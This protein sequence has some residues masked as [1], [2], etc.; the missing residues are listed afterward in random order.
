MEKVLV[1]GATGY[2]GLHCINQLLNEGYAVNGSVRSPERKEEVI[3]ALHNHNTSSE[4]L[5]LYAL[6]LTDDAGWSEAMEDCD[7]LLHVASPISL[8][9]T[10]E[11]Y[12]VQPAIDGVN[13]ALFFAKK[14]NI[15][16]VVLTSSVA[17]IFDSLEK[18]DIYDE[19][20]WSDPNNPHI[21]AYSKSKTLAEK[22]AWEFVEKEGHPF[23]LAVI[24][25][26]LVVG[27]SLSG[28]I[29]ESN[30]AV[31]MVASGRMPVAVPLMFGYVDVRDVAAAHIL[32]M[33]TPASNGER[34]ALVEKDLWYKDVAKILR[35]NGFEKA[36]TVGI[37]VWLAKILANFNK[38]LK[39]TLPYLGRKR[40]IKNLKAKEILGWNPRPAE[41][42]ILDI[43]NQMKDLGILK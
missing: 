19:S 4:Y 38:E 35:E 25:P 32:A 22:A 5:N 37:P 41:E 39:L 7:Y 30:K 9:R 24:N 27:A 10:D 13:R 18:K 20:D 2:I 21:S 43:A 16:K 34:F 29:G 28:D 31:E 15:K 23:E 12:F 36:P 1:T 42:S 3:N 26:A 14:H 11:D 40:S 6:N 17:A 8:E 33:Q